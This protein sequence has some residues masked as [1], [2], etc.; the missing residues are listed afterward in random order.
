MAALIVIG[1]VAALFHVAAAASHTVGGPGGGWDLSTDLEAWSLNQNFTPGDT[2]VFTYSSSHDVLEVTK[3]A[4][5]ACSAINPL[6]SHTGGNTVVKLTS[7]GKRY[8]ICSLPGHCVAGMKLKVEVSS[9][10]LTVEAAPPKSVPPLPKHQS[11]RPAPKRAKVH[12]SPSEAPMVAPA[13]AP[14]IFVSPIGNAPSMAPSPTS[15]A[16]GCKQCANIALK[17]IVGVLIGLAM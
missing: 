2:L 5:D 3:A 13:I 17:L 8:F 7:V 15:A 11:P 1:L 16:H 6:Q 9:K 10:L 4:Y 14:S 12:N